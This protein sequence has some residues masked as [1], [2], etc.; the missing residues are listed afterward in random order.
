MKEMNPADE[1]VQLQVRKLQDYITEHFY[2]C[3][4]EI[5]CG[6]GRMYA[7]GGELTDNIDAVGGAGT[8]EFTSKAIDIFYKSRN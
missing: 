5:L 4:D 1:Q 7:G 3:S 6:L 8:A 2:T